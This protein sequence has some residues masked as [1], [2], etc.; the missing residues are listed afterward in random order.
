MQSLQAIDKN[1]YL[2]TLLSYKQ[3]FNYFLVV[4]WSFIPEWSYSPAENKKDINNSN[5]SNFYT[6]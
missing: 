1:E 6:G 3:K 4:T 2:A 5:K